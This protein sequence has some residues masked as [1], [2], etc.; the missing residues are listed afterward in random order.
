M[1][2]QL[3]EIRNLPHPHP[4]PPLEGEGVALWLK[5]STNLNFIKYNA[6]HPENKRRCVDIRGTAVT[7]SSHAALIFFN[8]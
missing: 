2:L 5:F 1:P 6:D 4:S 7:L 3:A 8:G